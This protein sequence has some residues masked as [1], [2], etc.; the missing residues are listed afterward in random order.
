[1]LRTSPSDR[2]DA[3]AEH[4]TASEYVTH[5]LSRRTS[6]RAL[7]VEQLAERLWNVQ[8]ALE[9]T[10]GMERASRLPL[11]DLDPELVGRNSFGISEGPRSIG[12]SV[13]T[14][15]QCAPFCEYAK[16]TLHA[17]LS[18]GTYEKG[19]LLATRPGDK[20]KCLYDHLEEHYVA[21]IRCRARGTERS[22]HAV[23]AFTRSVL[24]Q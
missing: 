16:K 14:A 12:I 1:M 4:S 7:E 8:R 9:Q 10:H 18:G 20:G 15:V 5:G 2:G 3:V 24:P 17:S 6:K 11:A 13:A 19:H 21:V 22:R 23:D